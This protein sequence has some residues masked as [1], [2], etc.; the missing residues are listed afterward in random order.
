MY[1]IR[2]SC[3]LIVHNRTIIVVEFRISK[4]CHKTPIETLDFD[5]RKESK[6]RNSV[7]DLRKVQL[8]L[9]ALAT[10][11]LCLSLSIS[12]HHTSPKKLAHINGR[13]GQK[14]LIQIKIAGYIL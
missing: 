4:V 5:S 12:L 1:Y 7:K 8:F 10:L 14:R 9:G 6:L 13:R 2:L 11:V 3:I